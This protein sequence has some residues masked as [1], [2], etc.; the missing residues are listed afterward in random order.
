MVDYN[1]TDEEQIAALKSAWNE[2]G[3]AIVIGIVLGV[4][5]LVGWNYWQSYK[6]KQGQEAAELYSQAQRAVSIRDRATV[7][8][9]AQHLVDDYSSTPYA[10]LARLAQAKLLAEE[11]EYTDAAAALQ[12]VASNGRDEQT[13]TLARIRLASVYT[14]MGEPQKALD[15]LNNIKDENFVSLVAEYRGDAHKAMGDVDKAREQY[16]DALSRQPVGAAEFLQWKRDA[17][18]DAGATSG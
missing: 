13:S 5:V 10:P 12:W 4:L 6:K 16:D 3:R 9:L 18:G 17:L 14:A 8:Q 7:D 1:S 11:G 2:H 15:T